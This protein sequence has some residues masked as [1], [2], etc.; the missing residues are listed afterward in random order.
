MP[1][2]VDEWPSDRIPLTSTRRLRAVRAA[3]QGPRA[4]TQRRHGWRRTA[5]DERLLYAAAR[6][7]AITLRQAAT[8]YG[9]VTETARR[10]ARYM[11]EAGL[12]VRSDNVRWTGTLLSA[13]A[14]GI[15][16]STPP[17][18]PLLRE[19]TPGE[20]GLLHRLLLA[21]TALR[22]ETRGL[23]VVSER[24][25]RTLER[26]RDDGHAAERF[27]ARCGIH[28]ASGAG[29]EGD[30]GKVRPSVVGD[31]RPRW[32]AIPANTEGG[33]HWPDAVVVAPAGLLALEVEL[34]AKQPHRT[35]MVL[36]AYQWAIERGHFAQVLWLVTPDVRVQLEGHRDRHG[37]WR[38]GLLA[39]HG[40]VASGAP[41]DWSARR[42]AMVVRPVTPTD[43]GLAYA[44]SQRLLA[45]P[46]RCSYR[47]WR[48]HRTVWA[49]AGT[50]LDF[51]AWITRLHTRIR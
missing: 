48:Q 40:L 29:G 26:V 41:P 30:F 35:R 36:R 23:T 34:V 24:Q 44:L 33:L 32:W 4:G 7:G 14:A 12:L 51:E 13:T 17:G 31:G 11:A 39:E 27:A 43:D 10:R 25:A 42:H 20:G 5:A 37:H 21:E 45:P 22:A 15:A 8:F 16:A 38:D 3:H 49:A 1:E 18:H 19:I 50:S 9:G 2:W 6:F 28:T 47:Q 46:H